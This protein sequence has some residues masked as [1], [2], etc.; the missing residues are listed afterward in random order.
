M[1]KTYRTRLS[2]RRAVVVL[3]AIIGF[4]LSAAVDHYGAAPQ[5]QASTTLKTEAPLDPDEIREAEQR[6]ADLGYWTGPIDRTFDLASRQALIAFQKVEG[7]KRTGSI[8]AEELEALRKAVRPKPLESSHAH[9]EID[10][11]LQ[12]LFIVDARGIV[13]HILPVSTGSGQLFTSEGWSRRAI[14]PTGR[15]TVQRKLQGWHKSPLGL[16]YYPTYI[17]GGIAIHGNPLV[18]ATPA[19][20]GCIRIPM[21][22]AEELS[23]MTPVGTAVIVHDGSP[24]TP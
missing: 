24:L 19:S 4:I 21:F 22:A 11:K 1:K 9:V 8:N 20:H 7:R 10:L 15:F 23:E 17:L 16:L 5:K 14:T 2:H 13:S 3:T 18:P 12:V 6:L